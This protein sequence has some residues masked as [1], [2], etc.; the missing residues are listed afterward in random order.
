[1]TLADL[2]EGNSGVNRACRGQ[3][4]QQVAWRVGVYLLTHD[5]IC[6]ANFSSKVSDKNAKLSVPSRLQTRQASAPIELECSARARHQ[7]RRRSIEAGQDLRGV[8]R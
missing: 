6:L 3:Q 7:G 5:Q 4:G 8:S 2:V 1:M